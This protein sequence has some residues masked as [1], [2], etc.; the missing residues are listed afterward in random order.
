ML[1][2]SEFG[3]NLAVDNGNQSSTSGEPSCGCPASDG[4]VFHLCDFSSVD[5]QNV[6]ALR[7]VGGLNGVL[8]RYILCVPHT[9]AA[10]M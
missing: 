4:D 6:A 10:R 9:L 5:Q 1:V 3:M 8:S 7:G 2:S